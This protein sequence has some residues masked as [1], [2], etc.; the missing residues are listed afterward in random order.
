MLCS[1]VLPKELLSQALSRHGSVKKANLR[2]RLFA[3]LQAT[4]KNLSFSL[5]WSKSLQVSGHFAL[6]VNYL[7]LC[8]GKES[9]GRKKKKVKKSSPPQRA[10]LFVTHLEIYKLFSLYLSNSAIL[11]FAGAACAG[12]VC[13]WRVPMPPCWG[14]WW[15][16]SHGRGAQVPRCT[17]PA[18]DDSQ[19]LTPRSRAP[20]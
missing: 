1:S 17:C 18:G 13:A 3:L 11:G 2:L 6:E 8:A 20:P 15:C 16:D 5:C 10:V 4:K 19:G 9:V 14:C 12:G 7:L